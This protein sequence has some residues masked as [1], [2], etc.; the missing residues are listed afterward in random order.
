MTTPLDVPGA[1]VERCWQEPPAS[2]G[3]GSDA[4]FL[5]LHDATLR[6]ERGG[7]LGVWRPLTHELIDAGV[8]ALLR[9]FPLAKVEEQVAVL[10][11]VANSILTLPDLAQRAIALENVCAWLL[12]SLKTCAERG[13]AIPAQADWRSRTMDVLYAGLAGPG[14]ALQRLAAEALAVFLRLASDKQLQEVLTTLLSPPPPLPA[15][16]KGAGGAA[17]A[18]VDARGAYALAIG[19]AYRY[20]GG[21][22][23]NHVLRAEDTLHRL[24]DWAN[25][26]PDPAA[27][28][29]AAAAARVGTAEAAAAA[30]AASAVLPNGRTRAWIVHG[31]ALVV[32][33]CSVA[34]DNLAGACFAEVRAGGYARTHARTHA[35]IRTCMH[36]CMHACMGSMHAHLHAVIGGIHTGA[37]G[38]LGGW[39]NNCCGWAVS[40]G[41]A[42]ARAQHLHGRPVR[43]GAGV[44]RP[45]ADA[46]FE[47]AARG[48]GRVR[49]CSCYLDGVYRARVT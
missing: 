20:V 31:A 14:A 12:A 28:A 5:R 15:P 22:R 36:A 32:E 35:R 2:A 43:G 41:S 49:P 17:A 44:T 33:Y 26:V 34:S 3:G 13:W 7:V 24:L 16:K 30:A 8:V 38:V 6:R 47:G 10:G 11:A 42:G 1:E 48:L 9:V 23:I 46:L 18:A 45:R 4:R 40:T 27:A 25:G 37:A 21:M 39:C 29:A 19:C